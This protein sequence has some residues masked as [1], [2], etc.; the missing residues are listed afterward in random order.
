MPITT[1]IYFNTRTGARPRRVTADQFDEMLKRTPDI[2][3]NS[4][5]Y[6]VTRGVPLV[7]RRSL[8]M[9]RGE[10]S[11]MMAHFAFASGYGL[12]EHAFERNKHKRPE[13]LASAI[14]AGKHVLLAHNMR[15]S[16]TF[17]S[18]AKM[19][20]ED[21]IRP[22]DEWIAENRHN[23]ISVSVRSVSDAVRRLDEI[24]KYIP[25][26]AEMD[27]RVFALYAEGVADLPTY[28]PGRGGPALARS[29]HDAQ[30]L[31]TGYAAGETLVIEFP[32]LSS[33]VPAKKALAQNAARGINGNFYFDAR[34]ASK[35]MTTLNFEDPGFVQSPAFEKFW[36]Q[37]KDGKDDGVYVLAVST[38]RRP[39]IDMEPVKPK[40]ARIKWN[41]KNRLVLDPAAQ[42]APL[43]TFGHDM[44]LFSQG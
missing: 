38:L 42:I 30:D 35:Y 6:S 5:L 10:R 40:P 19:K 34:S 44:P 26:R 9:N 16:P 17:V 24:R 8:P 3:Q 41:V 39:H 18:F 20:P 23:Y 15:L 12:N 36:T 31:R 32:Q 2:R 33:F 7:F 28:F 14:G 21:K 11:P 1:A 13:S 37:L 25:R 22:V 43:S 4:E 29:F 27:K